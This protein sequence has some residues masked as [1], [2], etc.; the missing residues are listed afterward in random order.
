MGVS[1]IMGGSISVGY[2]ATMPTMG[3]MQK[4]SVVCGAAF[5]S[6][7]EALSRRVSTRD[8]A[9]VERCR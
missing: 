4:Y 6:G 9:P 3:Y 8:R 2:P 1:G 5:G 7:A